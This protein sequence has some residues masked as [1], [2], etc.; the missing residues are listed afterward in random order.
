MIAFGM[1]NSLLTFVDKYYEYDGKR[2]IQDKGLTMGGYE[3]AWLADLVAAFIL[4]NSKDLFLDDAIYDRI[5]R[6]DGVVVMNGIKMN[7]DMDECL[8]TF[9]ERVKVIIG[10]KK[11]LVCTMSL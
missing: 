10:Y 5:Y 2:E 3:L 6:D 4:E 11:G 8:K 7:A 9:Q 1:G